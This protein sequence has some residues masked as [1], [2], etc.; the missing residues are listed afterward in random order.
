MTKPFR[1]Y[2]GFDRYAMLLKSWVHFCYWV[3]FQVL[4]G[5]YSV[6]IT[7]YNHLNFYASHG[8]FQ[9]FNLLCWNF[10]PSI[11]GFAGE[12]KSTWNC[13]L[14]EIFTLI[15]LNVLLI[16]FDIVVYFYEY[17]SRNMKI[18]ARKIKMPHN[19]L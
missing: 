6:S 15:L 17:G 1:V 4:Q 18:F 14:K 11:L 2:Y 3:D 19:S 13:I 12:R 8:G 9:S 5:Q 16:L 10:L 7:P